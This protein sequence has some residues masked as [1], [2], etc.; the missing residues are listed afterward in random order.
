MEEDMKATVR[1]IAATAG[2]SPA[3]VSRYFS[4][5]E[6]VSP[7]T[8]LIL[9]DAM[10][11]LGVEKESF[12]KHSNNLI[13]VLLPH[14]HYGF[15]SDALRELM[16][17]APSLLYNLVFVPTSN[18]LDTIH[19]LKKLKP[20]G[21]IY[22]EEELDVQI[23]EHLTQ[24]N[25][26]TVMCGGAASDS[27]SDMVHVNDMAAAYQGTN[28]LLE[29]G[30]RKI[31]FLSDYIQ[32]ISSGYQRI[33]GSKRAMEEHGLTLTEEYIHYGPITYESGYEATKYFIEQK[34]DFTAIFA[35]TD[36]IA[37][38][39]MAALFDFGLHV[40]EDVSVLGFDDLLVAARIRP[41]LTTIHQPMK[42]IILKTLELF[43][44]PVSEIKSEIS[45]PNKIIERESC[46][47][48]IH[49]ESIL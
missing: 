47:S 48:V 10:V 8:C 19:T 18:I 38:G 2:V 5:S 32:K 36:E 44:Q 29:L 27:H 24:S 33:A 23:L 43:S 41:A 35:F 13:A 26:K 39:A 1:K 4:G 49:S 14:L 20:F 6:H 31:I 25:I 9:E 12:S 15:Y 37:I 45:L 17:C 21:S 46:R 30:H 3:T 22:F 40:P 34:L 16:E 28:Y 7:K 42:S 11:K